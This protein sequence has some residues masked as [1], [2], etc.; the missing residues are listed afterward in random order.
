MNTEG[1]ITASLEIKTE[2][3]CDDVIKIEPEIKLEVQQNIKTEETTFKYGTNLT[4][5]TASSSCNN[6]I[7]QLQTVVEQFENN[8][9]DVC[10]ELCSSY[11]EGGLDQRE[12]KR[13]EMAR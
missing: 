7:S 5:E 11:I 12:Q 13:K 1:N 3:S 8:Q 4:S 2:H 9:H 6:Y 10:P